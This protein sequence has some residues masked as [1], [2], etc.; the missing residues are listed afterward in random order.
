[1]ILSD[2]IAP[3]IGSAESTGF[4]RPGMRPFDRVWGKVKGF[5][6]KSGVQ[7]TQSYARVR[8]RASG[9]CKSGSLKN[10]FFLS[11]AVG[12]KSRKMKMVCISCVK[13]DK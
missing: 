9:R 5:F 1:M 2:V 3:K 4:W 10:P 13:K 11:V 12:G 7:R 8:G 6:F